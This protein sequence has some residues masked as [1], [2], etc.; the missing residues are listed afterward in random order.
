MRKSASCLAIFFIITAETGQGLNGQWILHY[1]L[2]W[3]IFPVNPH[4]KS[5]QEVC[6][7]SALA[8]LFPGER[9]VLVCVFHLVKLKFYK[10]TVCSL[11]WF[12]PSA[13][14]K[15][16]STSQQG[17]C[18]N[19]YT[20]CINEIVM[21]IQVSI[22]SIFIKFVLIACSLSAYQRDHNSFE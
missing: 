16:P 12:T 13:N 11:W 18:P 2:S 6:S 9:S 10:N 7:A 8:M 14:L 1:L 15:T 5:L 21:T 4:C 17:V 20:Q 22:A 19:L 3:G